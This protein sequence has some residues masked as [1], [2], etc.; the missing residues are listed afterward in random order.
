MSFETEKAAMA[1]LR[2]MMAEDGT[3]AVLIGPSASFRHLMGRDAN[4]TERLVALLVT[5][6]GAELIVPRLQAPLYATHPVDLM[7]WDEAED[8]VALL[9]AR[10]TELGVSVLGV[11]AEFWSGFL[12]RLADQAPQVKLRP[13]RA[14][15]RLRAIKTEAD[16]AGLQAA[17]DAIDRVW[18][19]F[20]AAVPVFTGKTELEL[21]GVI[22]ELMVAEGF[23]T[24]AWVDVGA[25]ANGASSLHH[26]SDYVI[27][28]GDPVVFD[29]AGLFG[30]WN[31]DI[32]RVVCAGEPGAEYRAAYDLLLTAQEAAFQA[33]RAGRPASEPDRVAREIL[34]DAGFGENF[35]HRVGHGIGLDVHEE[36][37]L[38]AGNDLLLAPGMVMSDEPGIY[39]P[40]RW[41]MRVE[42]IVALTEAGPQRLTQS[43]KELVIH[44]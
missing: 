1:R 7:V 14:L 34:S 43:P 17:A 42:D 11:N 23:S 26:G 27:R 20:L 18:A 8:P 36:P 12:L 31:G 2:G 19:G 10:L 44:G 25:G 32:A 3:E 35:T 37:Y 21:R 39:L 40:G 13:A 15:E 4:L 24:I 30:G 38:V 28:Q 16:I 22:R 6:D 33:I 41:G 5:Q 9:A 29:I